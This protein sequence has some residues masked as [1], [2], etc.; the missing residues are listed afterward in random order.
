MMNSE[1]ELDE[2]EWPLKKTLRNIDSKIQQNKDQLNSERQMMGQLAD[3]TR[4]KY[5]KQANGME[6]V[7]ED[8]FAQIDD[9]Y[10]HYTHH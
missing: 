7:Q 8:S 4:A 2:D 1:D 10:Q 3:E 6:E 9:V 5:K